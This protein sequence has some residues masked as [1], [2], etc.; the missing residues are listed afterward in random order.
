MHTWR[1]RHREWACPV[2]S[3]RCDKF[4]GCQCILVKCV[5]AANATASFHYVESVGWFQ[6][7]THDG[8]WHAGHLKIQFPYLTCEYVKICGK[9]VLYIY[10][11]LMTGC[12]IFMSFLI[13]ASLDNHISGYTWHTFQP[14]SLLDIQIWNVKDHIWRQSYHNIIVF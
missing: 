13:H 14:C 5:C 3:S 10:R 8:V 4:T 9:S 2:R 11:V 12:R 1:S 7:F 6:Y